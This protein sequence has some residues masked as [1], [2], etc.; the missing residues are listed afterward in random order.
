MSRPEVP[1]FVV[2]CPRSGTSL[3]RNLLRA[4]P[5]LSLPPESNFIPAF[6]HRYGD[7]GSDEAATEL[8][9]RI[10]EA[11]LIQRWRI[12]LDPVTLRRCRTFR[13]VVTGV[14]AAWAAREGKPRWGDKT[15]QY[16]LAIP[17]LCEI[18]PGCQ[19]V[20]AIRDGR[21]VALSYARAPFGPGNLYVAALLWRHFVTAGR[22]AGAALPPQQYT[23]VRYEGLLAAPDATMARLF[24]FL[25]E[26]PVEGPVRPNPIRRGP[27]ARRQSSAGYG[28]SEVF[29]N[30]TGKWKKEMTARNRGLVESV[31]GELLR[32]LGYEVEGLARPI[33]SAEDLFWRVQNRALISLREARATGSIRAALRALVR[34]RGLIQRIPL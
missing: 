1:I 18:F 12:D 4:H 32:E 24:D 16:A 15:P 5:R 31:C 20:H 8:A 30:N 2:G 10:L 28:A 33:S 14:Y 29:S 9:T 13:D 34:R 26:A 7:P 22:Q 27:A 19:I 3:L 21:D 25:G 23:E 11:P 6:Y 17:T